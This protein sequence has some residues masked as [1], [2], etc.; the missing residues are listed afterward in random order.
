MRYVFHTK[1]KFRV[2]VKWTDSDKTVNSF[3]S[4]VYKVLVNADNNNNNNNNNN[5]III[6]I[7]IIITQWL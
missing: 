1:N 3:I 5:Y 6:I 4:I 7:I 2:H